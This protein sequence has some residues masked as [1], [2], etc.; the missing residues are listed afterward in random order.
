MLKFPHP[1][2]IVATTILFCRLICY[3][4]SVHSF[5]DGTVNFK[6]FIETLLQFPRCADAGAVLSYDCGEP[7]VALL[8]IYYA[9]FFL[10][11]LFP[12]GDSIFVLTVLSL[13]HSGNYRTFPLYGALSC[14]HLFEI[15]FFTVGSDPDFCVPPPTLPF[16]LICT[17]ES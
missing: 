12:L 11:K 7:M 16:L 6:D 15:I 9:L 4:Q 2:D 14:V 17:V 10:F 1:T 8:I 5:Q 3:I 13:K